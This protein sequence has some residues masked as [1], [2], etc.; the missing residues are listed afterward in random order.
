ML[1]AK[2]NLGDRLTHQLYK[3]DRAV[4]DNAVTHSAMQ[5]VFF[6]KIYNMRKKPPFALFSKRRCLQAKQFREEK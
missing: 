6:L 3:F 1:G 5:I 2:N 4:R